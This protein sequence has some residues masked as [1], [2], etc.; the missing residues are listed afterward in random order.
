MKKNVLFT[1]SMGPF[2]LGWGEDQYDVFASRLSRGQGVFGL[3]GHFHAWGLYVIAENISA[4]TTVIE[5]PSEEMFKKELEKGYDYLGIQ[6]VTRQ[7]PRIVEMVKLAKKIAPETKI[8]LG[9]YGLITLYNPI[10]NDRENCAGFLLDNADYLCNEDGVTFFRRL[11]GDNVEESITQYY[12]PKCGI[13]FPGFRYLISFRSTTVLSA[14]GCPN[15][16][17]FCVTSAFFK[18]KKIR[19]STPEECFKY[20]KV[21][22]ERLGDQISLFTPVWDEDFLLDKE[23][24]MRLGELIR[25]ED[26]LHRVNF[27]CFGSI[28]S[29]SQYTPEELALCGVG[30]VW[31]GVESKF[32]EVITSDHH[33]EKR[34]GRDVAEVFSDFQKYGI[35]TVASTILGWDFHN[36]DN[37]IEDLDYFVSLKPVLYQISPLKPCPGTELFGK[38]KEQNRI[39]NNHTWEEASLW[40]GDHHKY[41]NFEKDE[42]QKYFDLAHE[43]LYNTN[44]S[45][46]LGIADIMLQGYRNMLHSPNYHLQMRADTCYFFAK[47]LCPHLL[48]SMRKLAPSEIVKRRIDDIKLKYYQYIGRFT[49]FEILASRVLY[50]RFKSLNKK[51][52][53]PDFSN[54]SDPPWRIAYYNGDKSE[55]VIKRRDSFKYFLEK[56]S[57]SILGKTVMKPKSPYN[58]RLRDI[59]DYN[60]TCKTI[61]IEGN[62]I[63]YI[64]EGEGKVILMLHGNLTWSYLYRHFIRGLS[65]NYRCIALDHLG[66][67]LSDKPFNGDYRMSAHIRRLG[68]FIQKLNLNNI[69][70]ICQDW[71]GI[72]GLSYAARNKDRFVRIIPMNTTGF[73]PDK[74]SEFLKCFSGIWAFPFLW[75]FKIPWLGKKMAMD[76]NIFLKLAMRLGVYNRERQMH[77]KAMLG[78]LYP[79]QRVVDRIAILKAVRQVAMLPGGHIWKLLKRTG[80]LLNGWDVRTQVIWG[81]KDKIFVP[82]FI[83][84]FEELLPNHAETLRI[85]TANHFLQDDEP[86]IIVEKIKSFMSEKIIEDDDREKDSSKSGEFVS[87]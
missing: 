14:L 41:L 58:I 20:L 18:K 13:T 9:G 80:E 17:E 35:T 33:I 2:E 29:I 64:D 72:I 67:G 79:F 61:D 12:M 78:Y 83:K 73:L 23:Y 57:S 66:Y 26:I 34:S 56:T 50:L 85:P 38:L 43:K 76:W 28:K 68:K 25:G 75:A 39:Y 32:D 40:G 86:D 16:C 52:Q 10:P 65:G 55:P 24:V 11:L 31:I 53:S 69:T 42:M 8:V 51:R 4:K 54:V 81:T 37:I 62:I 5:F 46:P 1:N 84:K 27:M 71:G 7:V 19:I 82:W 21:G 3:S 49:F 77:E 70:L 60:F 44:G 22:I 74:V 6:V 30:A 45:A 87:A 63:N 59:D 15:G 47:N 36:R 48:F